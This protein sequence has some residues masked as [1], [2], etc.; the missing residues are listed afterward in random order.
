MKKYEYKF[1]EVPKKPGIKGME[2]PLQNV[3]ILLWK[4]PKMAGV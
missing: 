2:I 1:I 4:K 3:K